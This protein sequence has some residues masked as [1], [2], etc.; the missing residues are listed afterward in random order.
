[1]ADVGETTRLAAAEERKVVRESRSWLW[2]LSSAAFLVMGVA[3]A[4]ALFRWQW[5]PPVLMG[6][7]TFIGL[8]AMAFCQARAAKVEKMYR[9]QHGIEG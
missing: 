8:T 4:T 1:M 2:W 3:A 7:V 9:E 6:T 5:G